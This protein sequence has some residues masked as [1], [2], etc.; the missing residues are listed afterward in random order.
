MKK[1]TVRQERKIVFLYQNSLSAPIIS[2]KLDLSLNQIYDTLKRKNIPRRSMNIQN[3]IR[4]ENSPLSFRFKKILSDKDQKLMIAAVMLYKGE[5]AKTGTTVDIVNSDFAILKLFLKFLRKIC[6]IQEKKLR[7]YLYCFSNQNPENLITF[8]SEK[9]EIRKDQFTKPYIRKTFNN[10][11][12][13]MPFGLLHIRYN[14]KRLLE[15]ILSLC[16]SVM[17]QLT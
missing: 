16:S 9:L 10:T 4:F 15:K 17:A 11:K 1:I 12:R 13:I 5:G 14:D 6:R 2:K 8:W 3:K 7:F